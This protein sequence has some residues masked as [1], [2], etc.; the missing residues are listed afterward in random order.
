MNEIFERLESDLFGDCAQ[1]GLDAF[2]L[3]QG[4][5]KSME[6]AFDT[7][8]SWPERGTDSTLWLC[9][10][11]YADATTTSAGIEI[12]NLLSESLRDA[13]DWG[14]LQPQ[15]VGKACI[16][17]ERAGML[18]LAASALHKRAAIQREKGL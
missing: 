14:S 1:Y 16:D 5:L 2:K 8:Q 15:N 3:L 6:Q 17:M 12:N 4:M 11:S 18:L 7:I 10:D 13:I 9:L